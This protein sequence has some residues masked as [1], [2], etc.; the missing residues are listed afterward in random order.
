MTAEV[1]RAQNLSWVTERVLTERVRI[2]ARIVTTTRLLQVPFRVEQLVV[3]LHEEV[4]EDTL[5]VQPKE[6]VRVHVHTVAGERIVRAEVGHE[7]LD[8]DTGAAAAIRD[9]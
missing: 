3:D 5:R 8:V 6:R 2:R 7:V 9:P 4:S 1:S